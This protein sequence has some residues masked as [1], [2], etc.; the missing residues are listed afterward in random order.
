MAG[1]FAQAKAAPLV[2]GYSGGGDS[3]AL[4]RRLTDSGRPVRAVIIDHALRE[5]SAADAARAA[6]LAEAAGA[7]PEVV[8]LA[9]P[10]GARP[11]QAAA[12]ALRMRALLNAAHAAEAGAVFLGHTLDDQAET[13]LLRAQAGS[14]WRGL[15]GMDAQSPFPLW[16]EGRKLELRRPL[17]HL[18][19]AALRDE[20]RAA[21]ADW[22]EDPANA[23]RR[24]ARV[25]ARAQLAAW[26]GGPLATPRW[27]ALS[28]RFSGMAAA[29]DFAA[30]ALIAEAARFDGPKI[31]LDLARFGRGDPD[32][33]LRALQ[34]LIAAA[35]GGAREPAGEAAAPLAA[36][37]AA[38]DVQA[39]TLGGA[40]FSA[41]GG[42]LTLSR[43]PGGV[44]GRNGRAG[45]GP[46]EIA[47]ETVWD[48]RIALTA[49]EPGWRLI[50]GPGGSAPLL[51]RDGRTLSVDEAAAA[52][53]VRAHWLQ[54]ERIAH[55]LW[56]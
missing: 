33:R 7:A 36:A 44:L 19:R 52:G 35:G 37:L 38:G 32:A 4:L 54:S 48:G 18:R 16:P 24:F 31:Q 22:L 20:L 29:Q 13:V 23:Q 46:Q 45:L 1:L 9:W 50:P 53:L 30:R 25:R 2:L 6:A 47:G 26:E 49:E 3:T 15:A 42:A 55:L 5:G 14:G 51:E 40:R 41:R 17:L 21:A 12:R 28:A 43:D 27:V 8:R 11:G 56:R 10:Q 34:A 39:G